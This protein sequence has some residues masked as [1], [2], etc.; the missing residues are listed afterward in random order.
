MSRRKPHKSLG[1]RQRLMRLAEAAVADASVATDI[2]SAPQQALA[3]T[4]EQIVRHGHDTPIASAIADLN[5]RHAHEAADLLGFWADDAAETLDIMLTSPD[6]PVHGTANFVVIPFFIANLGPDPLPV[7]LRSYPQFDR[8]AK[9]LRA[10]QLFGPEPTLY[11]SGGFYRLGDLA[12]GWAV[13]RDWLQH[14]TEEATGQRVPQPSATPEPP[15]DGSS[16]AFRAG[17]RFL[18]GVIFVDDADDSILW[19]LSDPD[20]PSDEVVADRFAMWRVEATSLM[21]EMLPTVSNVL[22]G[23]PAWWAEGVASGIALWNEMVSAILLDDHCHQANVVRDRVLADIRWIA[24][25]DA[26]HIVFVSPT[27]T[28]APQSWLVADDPVDSREDLTDYLR[29]LGIHRFSVDETG[30]LP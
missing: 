17:L 27:L 16:N 2:L 14:L 26:W 11:F 9:S 6:G 3:D 22:A 4:V 10:H 5:E 13:R 28:S 1:I 12:Q 8:L 29:A 19:D 18:V 21:E 24:E 30:L 15:H 25:E 7:D 20:A 23:D